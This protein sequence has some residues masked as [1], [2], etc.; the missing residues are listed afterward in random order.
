MTR[1]DEVIARFTG[2]SKSGVKKK[3]N[4]QSAPSSTVQVDGAELLDDVRTFVARFVAV[5]SPDYLDTIT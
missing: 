5:P 1:D 4:G 3:A 2:K